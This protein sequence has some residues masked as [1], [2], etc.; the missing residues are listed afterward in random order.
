M[1]AILR[2]VTRTPSGSP[3]PSITTARYSRPDTSWIGVDATGGSLPAEQVTQRAP[4][5]R[6]A[7]LV[8]GSDQPLRAHVLAGLGDLPGSFGAEQQPRPEPGDREQRGPVQD[9][10]Q[11]PGVVL[12][13]HRLGGDR[14]DGP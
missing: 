11:R 3:A 7:E 9:G 10:G 6:L 13:P 14:G 1:T 4:E 12:V 5:L 2:P 8:P